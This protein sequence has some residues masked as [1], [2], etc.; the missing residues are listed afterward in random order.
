MSALPF[1]LFFREGNGVFYPGYKW[2]PFTRIIVRGVRHYSKLRRD[3]AVRVLPAAFA[4]DPERL[5]RFQRETKMLASLN[6]SNIATIHGLDRS[7]NYLVMELVSA[8]TLAERVKRGGAVPI[9]QALA[10]CQQI[11]EAWKP[12]TRKASFTA[13]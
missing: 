13:T 11:A 4:H 12:L 6:H 2:A 8:E 5:S 10:I 7:M 3:A 9:E 1:R